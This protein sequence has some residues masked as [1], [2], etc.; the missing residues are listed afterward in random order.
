[1]RSNTC[2]SVDKNVTLVLSH[3]VMD[4]GDVVF[5]SSKLHALDPPQTILSGYSCLFKSGLSV[6]FSAQ[7]IC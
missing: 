4:I 3:S 2:Q 5:L 6:T 1:M 7:M